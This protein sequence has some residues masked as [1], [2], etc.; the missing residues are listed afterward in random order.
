MPKTLERIVAAAYLAGRG[1]RRIENQSWGQLNE[2]KKN[3]NSRRISSVLIPPGD[4][5][6][7]SPQLLE[8]H[9]RGMVRVRGEI[10]QQAVQQRIY[11]VEPLQL[12][13]QRLRIER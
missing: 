13:I 2:R 1:G 9:V 7:V 12:L 11:T 5:A 3:P 10:R 4:P 6:N 8:F